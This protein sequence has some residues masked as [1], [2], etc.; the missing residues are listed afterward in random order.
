MARKFL[1]SEDWNETRFVFNIAHYSVFSKLKN[2]KCE[3]HLLQM[4]DREHGKVFEK[5]FS[6]S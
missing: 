4:P 5:P 6:E 3:T 1:R 2:V